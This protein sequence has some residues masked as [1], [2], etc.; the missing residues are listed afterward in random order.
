[1]LQTLIR[2]DT[3]NPPGN[4]AGAAEFLESVMKGAALETEMVVHPSGRPTAIGRIPGPTDRPALVLL[5]HTDVVG[6]EADSWQRDPF[7]A[8]IAAGFV[9]GRGA[10]DMKSITV[11]HVMAANAL[12][13]SGAT[14][15]REVIVVAVPDEEAGGEA[16]ARWLL[17]EHPH[18][19]GFGDRPPPDVVGEGAF[20]VSGIL[21]IPVVAVALAEKSA[22]WLEVRAT[23][24]P[25]HGSLPPS[26]QALL[27][28]TSL[29]EDVSGFRS[30]RI[31]PVMR[32]QFRELGNR[33]L[34][35]KGRIFRALGSRGGGAFARLMA[36]KL[37]SSGIVGVLISD[38][39]TPTQIHGGYKQNVVPGEAVA[40][41][42]CRLLPDTDPD[43]V[44]A[45][46]RKR[47]DKA[48]AAVTEISRHSGPVTE[49][50]QLF[51]LIRNATRGPF[52][53]AIVVPTISPAMTDVRYFRT[54]GAAGYGWVPLVIEPELIGT[55]HGH[56]ERIP[57]EGFFSA[58]DGMA[59][60]VRDAAT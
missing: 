46:I 9:W 56:N 31:H 14:P 42:D 44:V 8:E 53:D 32:K 27:E 24:E 3:T 47:A 2:I 26:R 51:D 23:G 15:R 22:L 58:V 7:G 28:L 1:M 4:E 6:V 55:I 41:F 39:V 60:L 40:S 19:V 38:A 18:R 21:D 12:A 30:A 52:S 20:G 33:G 29:V 50:G 25:G 17:D 48:G 36:R 35:A 37:R 45:A 57:I 34:G 10:L 49:A 11:M 59:R 54:K 16:G 5:S 43:A 13:V